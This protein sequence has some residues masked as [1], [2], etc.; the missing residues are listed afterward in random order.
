MI[1]GDKV[2]LRRKRLEDAWNDYRWKKDA[3]LAH[4][5]AAV[6]LNMPYSLYLA[7]YSEEIRYAALAE[8]R[9][10]IETLDGKHIGNCSCY[11]ID[12]ARAEAELG[13]LIGDRDY[14]DKGY[15]GDAVTALVSFVFRRNNLNRIYLHTLEENARAQKCFEKCGFVARGRVVRGIHRFLLMDIKKADVAPRDEGDSSRG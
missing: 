13:I 7:N 8:H 4:L 1:K 14:W 6:P 9:Y 15:G 3:K 10:A 2:T 11:N 5:D 12:Y